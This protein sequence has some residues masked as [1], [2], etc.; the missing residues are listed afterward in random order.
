MT[1]IASIRAT[2]ADHWNRWQKARSAT[3]SQYIDWG[4][5]PTIAARIQA[6]LFGSP[7]F[8]VFDYLKREFPD[9]ADATVLSLCAGDGSFEKLLLTHGIFGSI[10]GMDI[11][12]E[13][14]AA[15]NSAASRRTP[16]EN[17]R[18]RQKMSETRRQAGDN[19]L[20]RPHAVS[21]DRCAASSGQ[22]L[23]RH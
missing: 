9:F 16:G 18:R 1:S 6:E 8:T 7:S 10:T 19:R 11:A 3:Q 14:V 21:V 22:S 15:G 4:D 5:H 12:A 2:A 20:L 17:V 23:H 13:R